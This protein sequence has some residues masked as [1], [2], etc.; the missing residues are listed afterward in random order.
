[1]ALIEEYPYIKNDKKDY[2]RVRHYSDTG[3]LIVQTE[4]GRI[5]EDAVDDYP[6]KYSY[7]EVPAEEPQI[8]EA[9]Y[10]DS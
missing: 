3:C 5:Y 7:A 8:E 1:M 10:G 4:T 9:N 6:C 2:T